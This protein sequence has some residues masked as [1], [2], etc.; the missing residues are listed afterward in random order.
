MRSYDGVKRNIKFDCL[1]FLEFESYPQELVVLEEVVKNAR[2]LKEL[3]LKDIKIQRT[4]KPAE[5]KVRLVTNSLQV[6][7]LVEVV[8]P[9]RIEI[10]GAARLLV[11]GCQ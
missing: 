2:N 8:E 9:K 3:R 10:E 1:E 4:S 6:L 5:H 11:I 7:D